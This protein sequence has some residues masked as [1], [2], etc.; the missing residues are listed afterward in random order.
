M[1]VIGSDINIVAHIFFF[2]SVK[3]HHCENGIHFLLGQ[4]Y[5][6][7][8]RVGVGISWHLV[9]RFRLWGQRFDSEAIIMHL[10]ATIYNTAG[11]ATQSL[12]ITSY[13]CDD[14]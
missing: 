10:D 12:L 7:S 6:D 5:V 13:F 14:H 9:I 1:F 11:F 8:Y 4:M 3:W 2:L